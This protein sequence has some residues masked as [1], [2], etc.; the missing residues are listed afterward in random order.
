MLVLHRGWIIVLSTLL[1]T[2][3][4]RET[5]ETAQLVFP[6]IVVVGLV[7]NEGVEVGGQF[8]LGG[9]V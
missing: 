4:L 6:Y 7:A 8:H 5:Q 2:L 3:I 1:G 9:D